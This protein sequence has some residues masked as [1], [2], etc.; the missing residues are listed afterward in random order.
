MSTY[1]QKLAAS[2]LV[3]F[4]GNIGKAMIAAGYSPKTAKTPQKLTNSRG[5]KSIVDM[6]SPEEVA[7]KHRELLMSKKIVRVDTGR[8]YTYLVRP[9]Y[10]VAIKAL[11]LYYK[12]MGYYHVKKSSYE[13]DPYENK[14]DDELLD[15]LDKIRKNREE[16]RSHK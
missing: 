6:I 5:F 1:K 16:C 15:I 13:T 9:N 10:K 4:G 7:K 8:G 3:E 11:D 14:S 12:V 2:K